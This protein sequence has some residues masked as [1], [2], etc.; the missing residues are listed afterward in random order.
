[1]HSVNEVLM[2][3]C[4][5]LIRPCGNN[6]VHGQFLNADSRCIGFKERYRGDGWVDV[7]KL[8]ILR[9]VVEFRCGCGG[10]S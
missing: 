1:M 10:G 6:T 8:N 4:Q 9:D 3:D 2:R 5:L 7:L